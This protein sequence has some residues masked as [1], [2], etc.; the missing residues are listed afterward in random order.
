M[1]RGNLALVSW[2]ETH[3]C[4]EQFPVKCDMA[5]FQSTERF[6]G[7]PKS[8]YV[9]K[10]YFWQMALVLLLINSTTQVIEDIGYWIVPKAKK[11]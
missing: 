9:T 8:F 7:L 4:P 1:N 6:Y 2:W 11:S 10:H 3:K 5:N